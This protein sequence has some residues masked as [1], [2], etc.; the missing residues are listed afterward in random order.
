MLGYVLATIQRGY[1][2]NHFQLWFPYLAISPAAPMG[3]TAGCA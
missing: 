3:D 1:A 2:V